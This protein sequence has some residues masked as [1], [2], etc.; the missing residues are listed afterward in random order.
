M[1]LKRNLAWTTLGQVGFFVVQFSGSVV[2]ARLLSPRDMGVYAVAAAVVGVLSLIEGLGLRSYV[3]REVEFGAREAA[4]AFTVHAVFSVLLSAAILCAGLVSGRSQD[5]EGVGS[6]LLVLSLLPLVGIFE[7]LP[8]ARLER[9]GRFGPLVAVGFTR[10]IAT[11]VATLAL[12]FAGQRYLSI[13]YGQLSGAILGAFAV[14]FAGRQHVSFRLSL[15]SWKRISVFGG[16]MLTMTGAGAIAT[17]ASELLL[18]KVLGLDAMG[19]YN[20]ASTL[21]TLFFSNLHLVVGRVLFVDLAQKRREGISLRESYLLIVEMSTAALWPVFT[22]L[23]VLAHPLFV[24]VYGAKWAAAATPF[25]LLALSA[26]V[27]VAITM[28]VELFTISQE[29]GRQV[30]IELVRAVVG[31]VLFGCGTLVGLSGAAA[32]RVVEWVFSF[33]LYRPHIERMTD[34][35]TR[36][37]LPIYGRSAVLT[38]LAVGPAAAL[39]LLAPNAGTAPFWQ[40]AA[41]VLAGIVLWAIGLWMMR[42]R[43]YSEA[44]AFLQRRRVAPVAAT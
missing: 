23:A 17:R 12:A 44:V 26:V 5:G 1:A 22:G 3:V 14:T 7:F 10:S 13:A 36:D 11:T 8:S 6:V 42:H 19:L 2:L 18:G 25:A 4:T 31:T 9:E 27:Q 35:T 30:R 24:I 16:H 28:T 43:L 20:R 29:T 41:V 15:Q 37:A 32:A 40:L 38:L 33:F 21:N 34:T 39:M